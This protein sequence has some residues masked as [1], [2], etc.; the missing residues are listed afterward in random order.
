MF[1]RE[2]GVEVNEKEIEQKE[3]L[4]V[5]VVERAKRGWVV[6]FVRQ[7]SSWLHKKAVI[8]SSHVAVEGAEASI[9][10]ES[11]RLIPLH[12]K[13]CLPFI[14]QRN[15]PFGTNGSIYLAKRNSSYVRSR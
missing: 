3:E 13:R 10:G 1:E 8:T 15:Q 4:D 12:R 7:L 5:E 6:G 11:C 2:P 14:F 9:E